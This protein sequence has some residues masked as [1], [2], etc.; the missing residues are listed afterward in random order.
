MNKEKWMDYKYKIFFFGHR[1]KN[2]SAMRTCVGFQLN[3][4]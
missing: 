2:S 3:K 4:R 1:K